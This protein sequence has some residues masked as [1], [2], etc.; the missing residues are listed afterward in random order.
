MQYVCSQL[1][2]AMTPEWQPVSAYGGSQKTHIQPACPVTTQITSPPHTVWA[3][4]V[5]PP[6]SPAAVLV[7][8]GLICIL[9]SWLGL[10]SL[11]WM[12]RSHKTGNT[13]DAH[14]SLSTNMVTCHLTMVNFPTC[15]L[16]LSWTLCSVFS[17]GG[18]MAICQLLVFC[19]LLPGQ[20]AAHAIPLAWIALWSAFTTGYPSCF[21]KTS[22]QVP[23][24]R[25][26][27][28]VWDFPWRLFHFSCCLTLLD[29]RP[30]CID[31]NYV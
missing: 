27:S 12:Q 17:L 14:T 3:L 1:Q 19:T 23:F 28:L 9:P 22:A 16:A 26:A 7:T 24:A 29:P 11:L 10:F 5:L 21:S 20:A 2:H 30:V 31:F 25:M 13:N 8:Y 6:Q 18:D 15:H 4:L